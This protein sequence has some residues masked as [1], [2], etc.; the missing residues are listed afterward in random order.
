MKTSNILNYSYQISDGLTQTSSDGICMAFDK[1]YGIMFCAYMPGP[2]GRYG[3]SRGRIVLT[4][5]PASQ[6][7]NSKTIDI[8][9]DKDVFVPNIIS[10][11]DGAVR[12]FYEKDSRASGD[13]FIGYKDF[14]FLT[15]TLTEEKYVMLKKED[16]SIVPLTASEQFKYLE[17]KGYYNHEFVVSE[18][19]TFGGHT[20][21]TGEDGLLY[22]SITSYL[23]EPILYRSSDNLQT[24]EF[25]A[26][27]PHP[28]QYEMDYKI[29][30][31]KIY[32]IY[33]TPPQI[34]SIFLTQSEDG[35]KTWSEPYVIEN[36]VSC[37]PRIILYNGGVLY[38]YNHY[39]KDSGNR[40]PVIEG[41]SSIRIY[42]GTSLE[43]DKNKLVADLYS[44]YGM[45]NV[46][47]IDILGDVYLGYS[48]S[49]LALEYQ[50]GA[51]QVRGKDAIRYVKLGDM[52]E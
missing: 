24:I 12:V 10:L 48:T 43:N 11:G 52:L 38:A 29:L 3:E 35:G 1:K 50:N 46:C 33:R 36:S 20:V 27:C 40:P 42:Y 16:G 39:V 47:M 22:G 28:A 21:F 8:S 30:N 44:K 18:Q 17:Q 19:M 34:N 32:A 31:G 4:Y 23:A 13:H 9:T 14:N 25:F 45:V 26:V 7:F 49:E 5:F 2:Q 41:R 15:N 51:P 37:R 6:P